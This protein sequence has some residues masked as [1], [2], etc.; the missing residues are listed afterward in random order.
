MQ[1]PTTFLLAAALLMAVG[2]HAQS[3]ITVDAS[4]MGAPIGPLHYG[5]FFE[6]INHA[7]DGG[8]YAELI[9]NRSFEDDLDTK[10]FTPRPRTSSRM[11]SY[12]GD[13]GQRAITAW[14]TIGNARADITTD[15][16]LNQAQQ[17]CLYLEIQEPG[18]GIQNEGFWGIN[19]VT[20]TT[21]HLSFWLKA[22]QKWKGTIT[23]ALRSADGTD[24]G[25]SAISV[26]AHNEWIRLESTI[27]ATASDPH[28]SLAMTSDSP[29][30]LYFDVV[31]LFPP[32]Y[33]NRPN[34]CRK[35]LAEM[36]QALHPRFMRFPGGCYVEGQTTESNRL[37]NRFEWYNTIGPIEQRPGH[38]S[39]NWHYNVSD[40]LGFHEMLQLSEDLGAAP[41]FVVNVGIG[42]GWVQP[43][44]HIEAYIQE[45]LDAL[46]YANGPVT[47]KWGK[48]RAENGHP[49][50]FNLRLIEVGN[51]NAN[52]YFDSNRDQ[53]DHYFE[54]YEQFYKAIK[55]KYPDVQII[56]NVESWGT[57]E[58]SWRSTLPVDLLDEHYYRSP[59]WFAQRY[60]KYDHYDRSGP[61]IYVGEY[62]VT[63]DFGV[64]GHLTAALGEAIYMM[65][66]ERNADVV[67]MASYAP[68]FVNENDQ[69][70]RPDMIRF[71]SEKCFGTPSYWV[72]QLMANHVGTQNVAFDITDNTLPPRIGHQFGLATWSTAAWFSNIKAT[73]LSGGEPIAISTDWAAL[74]GL[75]QQQGDWSVTPTAIF[76]A[77]RQ[78]QGA[79]YLNDSNLGDDYALDLDIAR[80]EGEEGAIIVFGYEN[81]DNYL[82]W[83]LG[84]WGNTQHAVERVSAGSKSTVAS[85][86]GQL[87]PYRPYH[88][89][90]ELRGSQ[91]RCLLDGQ[92]VHEFQLPSIQRVYAQ[93]ALNGTDE[94]I[95]KLVNF[96]GEDAPLNVRLKDFK[97]HT[98]HVYLLSS[99]SGKDENT[100]QSPMKVSPKEGL[101]PVSTS[102]FSFTAEAYSLSILRLKR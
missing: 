83:N 50:P 46:E 73:R 87:V 96:T 65:G 2:L 29:A 47:S 12:H 88:A 31:S 42:H 101:F 55:A 85:V 1:K 32:T 44:D 37:Q 3:T 64:N 51:E 89:R 56:G 41:L 38:L 22:A 34:G 17:A 84:G 92:V 76:Q 78:V 36:L 97:P 71:N 13:L 57:D 8:I 93:A 11:S 18:A 35:D 30:R 74:P 39:V 43:Y 26:T 95:I 70:W 100:M 67:S 69:A 21:Y 15:N 27:T 61:K 62:A 102:D 24:L 75:N 54:R 66:T 79:I 6:E 45:A 19:T 10:S 16:L 68:I 60:A 59:S 53:S 23:A 5:I 20:G 33:K 80:T 48:R 63:S 94:L 86:R 52:F 14:H 49:E 72:Q 91:V 98:G 40:G 25:S 99:T 58:P 7:G 82:W 9:R 81:E 77:N 4:R 28:A 90:I